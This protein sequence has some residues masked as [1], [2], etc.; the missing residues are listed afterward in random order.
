MEKLTSRKLVL[1]ALAMVAV[2]TLA[3]LVGFFPDM[4]P[5]ASDALKG[6]VVIA[7]V[8]IGGQALIDT[9]QH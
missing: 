4:G 2:V 1:G 7:L 5:F 6:V 3:T 8:G 9:I